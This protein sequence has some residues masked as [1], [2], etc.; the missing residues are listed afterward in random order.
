MRKTKQL[1]ML[2]PLAGLLV[3]AGCA[4]TPPRAKGN[5]YPDT[6]V[7]PGESVVFG[8]IRTNLKKTSP[9]GI[10]FR[11]V[12]IMDAQRS[13]PVMTQHIYDTRTP[14]F[15]HLLPGKYAVFE[16]NLGHTH[17][18]SI[19]TSTERI[20]AEFDVA[21]GGRIIYVGC[22]DLFFTPEDVKASLADDFDGA[23]SALKANYPLVIGEPVKSLFKLENTR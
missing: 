18:D 4:T 10:G 22:L 23:V 12:S 3:T 19:A 21:S 1:A 11:F 20:Y 17:A 13:I 9:G 14:F 8:E 16:I 5:L 2:I 7:P 15:W 6:A